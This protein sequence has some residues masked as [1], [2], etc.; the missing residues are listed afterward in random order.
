MVL[1]LI[2][3]IVVM[4][5]TGGGSSGSISV[6]GLHVSEDMS[7]SAE[8]A[9]ERHSHGL[10]LSCSSDGCELSREERVDSPGETKS[11]AVIRA[12]AKPV[13]SRTFKGDLVTCGELV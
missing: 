6:V 8:V 11:A 9:L 12:A 2:F 3:S 4:I 10:G 7:V 5:T 13:R 1:G